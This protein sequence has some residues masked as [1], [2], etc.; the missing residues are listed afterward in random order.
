LALNTASA[1]PRAC[2]PAAG[3]KR[4]LP[5][6]GDDLAFAMNA[7]ARGRAPDAAD[8]SARGGGA[9]RA[10]DRA[11]AG[12]QRR[13]TARPIMALN[14][15]ISPSSV[16][17]TAGRPRSWA[18]RRHTATMPRSSFASKRT[19]ASRSAR[20][21][22]TWKIIPL[23]RSRQRIA[24]PVASAATV[25]PAALCPVATVARA[26]S[27]STLRL[28]PRLAREAAGKAALP[29]LRATEPL[30][31]RSG[32]NIEGLCVLGG[33][34][35]SP[36]P[37]WRVSSWLHLHRVKPTCQNRRVRRLNPRFP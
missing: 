7:G 22:T 13:P 37:S 3:P 12:E 15:M 27:R 25:L 17:T 10:A 36:L 32:P 24:T 6:V 1:G 19:S 8:A 26:N 35:E 23:R 9:A 14:A 16:S 4:N 2:K 5:A 30:G 29:R 28:Q 31:A 18:M 33:T 21:G 11:A 20:A 34:D